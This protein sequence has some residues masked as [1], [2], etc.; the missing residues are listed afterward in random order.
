MLS[1]SPAGVAPLELAIGILA[2]LAERYDAVVT[3]VEVLGPSEAT[4]V[5]RIPVAAA[6]NE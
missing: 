1:P 3:S 4:F 5:L 6:M 2:H